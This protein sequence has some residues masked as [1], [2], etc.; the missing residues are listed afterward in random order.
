MEN[1]RFAEELGTRVVKLNGRRVA[2]SL[3]DFARREGIT[4]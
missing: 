2:G 1:I 4:L 3:I